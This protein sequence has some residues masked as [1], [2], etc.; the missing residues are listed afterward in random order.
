MK[1]AS[2]A[3]KISS[4]ALEKLIAYTEGDSRIL[5]NE[6]E[7]LAAFREKGEILDN[8]VDLLTKSKIS[9]TIFETIEAAGTGNKKRAFELLHKQLEKKEDPFYV[10]SMYVYQFR[11][12]LKIA[13]L[14]S[15]NIRNRFQIAKISKIHPY[16]VQKTIPQLRNFSVSRLKTILNMLRKTDEEVKT[17]K[18]YDIEVALD[19]LIAK[20]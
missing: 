14:Y 17:G 6:I 18:I 10:F 8:D 15:R 19:R 5:L 16:V 4:T 3:V 7:K 13:D 2:P 1:L 11:N 9:P 20:I 12:L